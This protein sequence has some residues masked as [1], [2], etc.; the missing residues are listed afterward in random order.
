MQTDRENILSDFAMEM[1]L[2]AN[3]LRAYIQRYPKLALELT[4]LFHEITMVD[5]ANAVGTTVGE[6][7]PEGKGI[8][9]GVAM[10]RTAL[11]GPG[12]RKL[13]HRLGLPRDFVAAFRDAKVRPGSVPSSVLLNL[14]RAMDVKT[15]YFIA[16][17]QRQ[18]GAT[19]M[20]AFKADAK[21]QG[22]SVLEYNEFIESLGLDVNE[23][24][25]L[26]RLA[27]SDGRH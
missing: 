3:V 13:A 24:A 21:P 14:A 1:G 19:G 20:V 2:T 8:E 22:L 10:V 6:E 18:S 5:L 25:A 15:Q 26:E 11:S 12:L 27:G 4:D 7:E 16:Y 17:L 9:E 23:A